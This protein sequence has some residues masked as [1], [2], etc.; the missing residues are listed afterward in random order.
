[1]AFEI[2]EMLEKAGDSQ[3][4]EESKADASLAPDDNTNPADKPTDEG[5]TDP[6]DAPADNDSVGPDASGEP[7]KT[8]EPDTPVEPKMTPDEPASVR[9]VRAW[10]KSW[11]KDAKLARTELDT[12]KPVVEVVEQFGGVEV[13]EPILGALMGENLDAERFCDELLTHRGQTGYSDFI[14]GVY[15]RH[16]DNFAAELFKNPAEIAN[17][18][19]RQ[20]VEEFNRFQSGK[21]Q[22]SDAKQEGTDT[23][24]TD[25]LS[26]DEIALLPPRMQKEIRDLR[27]FRASAQKDIDELKAHRT[28]R[29][30]EELDKKRQEAETAISRRTQDL[31]TIFTGV[32]DNLISNVSF[33]TALD[34]KTRKEENDYYRKTIKANL[35]DDVREKIRTDA[36]AR[37][38]FSDLNQKFIKDGDKVGAKTLL[39]SAKAV[40]QQL[41]E[42]HIRKFEKRSSAE[43]DQLNGTKE[44]LPVVLPGNG[45][46]AP[47]APAPE[48]SRRAFDYAAMEQ[49]ASR[50]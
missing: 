42:P 44:K 4:S 36:D 1:M 2:T 20:Q 18:Q 29:E 25:D 12:V 5:Q 34:E 35:N 47:L 40:I 38:T 22:R 6:G 15:A 31:D 30:S 37:K 14:W 27:E 26:D 50:Q 11:E 13:V 23:E 46:A 16:T 24:G 10:G 43:V 48:P 49:K 8:D 28:K 3:G 32:I 39:Q 41:A 17:P 19:L 33:S 45:Q 9:E 7:A 21:E